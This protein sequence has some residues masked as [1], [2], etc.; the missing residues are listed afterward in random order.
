MAIRDDRVIHGHRRVMRLKMRRGGSTLAE[1]IAAFTYSLANA[2]YNTVV[3]SDDRQS[4]QRIV[5]QLLEPLVNSVSDEVTQALGVRIELVRNE[6]RVEHVTSDG[7][8]KGRSIMFIGGLRDDSFGLG[9]DIHYGIMTEAAYAPERGAAIWLDL[10]QAVPF[11]GLVTEETTARGVGG[12][13][14]KDWIQRQREG[15][16]K[17]Q[18][19]PWHMRETATIPPGDSNLPQEIRGDFVLNE[20]E[21]ALQREFGVTLD[22]FRFYRFHEVEDGDLVRQY[23]PNDAMEAFRSTSMIQF[24]VTML[25][26]MYNSAPSPQA[27]LPEEWRG[28][29]AG[30]D[31]SPNLPPEGN[32]LRIF[33]LPMASRSYTIGIDSGKGEIS[34]NRTVAQV[35]CDQTGQQVAIL[36]GVYRPNETVEKVYGLGFAYKGGVD[37]AYLIPEANGI[38]AGICDGLENAMKYPP[39]RLFRHEPNRSCGYSMTRARKWELFTTTSEAIAALSITL[40]D[41]VTISEML[42]YRADKNGKLSAPE[43]MFDDCTD[44]LMLACHNRSASRIG[45]GMPRKKSTVYV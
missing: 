43:G 28:T 19:F 20:R 40:N 34:S 26:D 5:S 14:H 4:S 12:Q 2:N 9:Y 16:W 10:L 7:R 21:E 23:Y 17:C 39:H 35:L 22:Q 30:L 3:A 37:P 45:L 15:T 42:T 29:M 25:E 24:P 33:E 11:D 44:A 38:G 31:W 13:F 8:P 1:I 32:G 41:Q 6:L 27:N 36:R 18:F